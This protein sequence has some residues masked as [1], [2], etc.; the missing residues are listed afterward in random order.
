MMK[1]EITLIF[2]VAFLGSHAV[3]G[4]GGDFGARKEYTLPFRVGE[5]YIPIHATI[6]VR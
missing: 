3:R 5:D 6:S 1:K 4:A 2:C